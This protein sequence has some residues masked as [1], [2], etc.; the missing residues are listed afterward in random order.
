MKDLVLWIKTHSRVLLTDITNGKIESR[1]HH[2]FH[3]GKQ[4]ARDKLRWDSGFGDLDEET[5][6]EIFNLL[7]TW[8]RDDFH[9]SQYS[10][11]QYVSDVWL[12]EAYIHVLMHI[13]KLGYDAAEEIYLR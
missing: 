11:I 12:P 1:R 13:N 6:Q 5:G 4:T 2:T 8:F 3:K 7:V 10:A 9:R